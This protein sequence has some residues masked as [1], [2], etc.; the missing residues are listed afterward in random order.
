MARTCH[1]NRSK[2][3]YVTNKKR[4]KNTA[5]HYKKYM[6]E[7]LISII[8]KVSEYDLVKI[9]WHKILYFVFPD[10]QTLI[11]YRDNYFFNVGIT[12]A[13]K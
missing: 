13:A 7:K 2:P 12:H 1:N 10:I 5:Q 11:F 3:I 8:Q 4:P 9:T 6:Q